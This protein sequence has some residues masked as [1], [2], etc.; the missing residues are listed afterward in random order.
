MCAAQSTLRPHGPRPRGD[1]GRS[2][3]RRYAR[4]TRGTR[5][6]DARRQIQSVWRS[7]GRGLSDVPAGAPVWA[8]C[9]KIADGPPLVSFPALLRQVDAERRATRHA[10]AA[11]T[12]DPSLTAGRIGRGAARPPQRRLLR[13]TTTAWS[14]PPVTDTV[15]RSADGCDDPVAAKGARCTQTSST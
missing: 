5:K 15:A 4:R 10:V 2:A 3:S 11:R 9:T 8:T 7:R 12:G 1:A 6:S 14:P 13:V